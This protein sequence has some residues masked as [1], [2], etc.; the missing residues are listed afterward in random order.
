MRQQPHLQ[1]QGP[2]VNIIWLG[3][4][5]FR[6]GIERQALLVDPWL[7]DNPVLTED[8]HETAIGGATRLLVTHGQSDH[9]ADMVEPQ[10]LHPIRF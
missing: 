4:G 1:L 10:I 5:S 7:Q 2:D 9:T 6:I 3:H 8:P